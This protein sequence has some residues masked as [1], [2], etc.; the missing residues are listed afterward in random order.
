MG[1]KNN[2]SAESVIIWQEK[3]SGWIENKSL[4]KTQISSTLH[5]LY[6]CAADYLCFLEPRADIA[7][8]FLTPCLQPVF[9]RK[10][11]IVFRAK[12]EFLPSNFWGA[13][14]KNAKWDLAGEKG[15]KLKGFKVLNR[16]IF[17]ECESNWME[18]N[19]IQMQSNFW[20]PILVF[21]GGLSCFLCYLIV[22][23]VN[24]WPW[25][26]PD[27]KTGYSTPPPKWRVCRT[28]VGS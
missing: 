1:K 3:K 15:K 7:H 19:S 20:Q 9:F 23:F 5:S 26:T 2:F 22:P 28:I 14:E 8:V 12:K 6:Y 24:A 10:K 21:W 4:E 16:T 27:P 17:L 18:G 13:F 11:K 25:V